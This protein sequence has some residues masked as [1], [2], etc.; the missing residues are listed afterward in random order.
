[1]TQ[2]TNIVNHGFAWFAARLVPFADAA[3]TPSTAATAVFTK[4]RSDFR[5]RIMN[6]L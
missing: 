1:M 2:G 5:L 3:T 6:F 4:R